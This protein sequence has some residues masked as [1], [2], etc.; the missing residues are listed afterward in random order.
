MGFVSTLLAL[1][2]RT[3]ALF[4]RVTGPIFFQ[5][6]G[7]GGQVFGRQF[8]ARPLMPLRVGAN[9][10]LGRHV[11]W[12]AARVAS[13][14]IGANGSINSNCVLVASESI[15]IGDNVAIGEMVSIRDQEH[16]FKPSTGVRGQGF[17]VAPI[18][19]EDNC[20]IG[21]GVY[22]G[23]GSRIGAGSIVAANSVVRGEFP[24]G[25]LIAGAPAVVKRQLEG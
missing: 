10:M 22:I 21:R 15:S 16:R 1:P 5:R 3:R 11:F 2:C 13:I 23:P 19:I 20:W 4:Y 17:H 12:Q 24:P 25:S 6:F 9:V 18:V 14:S 7:S 8:F